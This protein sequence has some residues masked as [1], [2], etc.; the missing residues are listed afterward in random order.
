MRRVLRH[1]LGQ[2]VDL[3]IGHLQHAADVAQHAARLQGAEGD[4]LRHL[5]A[6]VA[7]LHV[8]DHLVA[9]VLAE[10]DVEVGHRHALGIEEALEQQAEADGIEIGDGE[11][12]GDQRARAR[13][14][15]GPDRNALRLR[16]FDEVGNDQE[17]A[18]IFHAL[19]DAEL[20]FQPLAVL[21]LGVALGEPLRGEPAGE[22]LLGL[23]AQFGGL[24]DLAVRRR[25]RSAAGSACASSAGRRSARRSRPWRPSPPA[26]RQ[27]IQAFPARLEAML[28][29]EL[30]PVALRE[31]AA[32]GDAD[33]RV[34][35]FVVLRGGEIGLVGGDQRQALGV[36][37][38][39]QRRLGG[40]L[41]GTAVALQFDIE[42]VAEQ[43][44][45]RLQ[46]R[47]GEMALPGG[48]RAVERAA[49]PAGERDHA[50]GFALEPVELQARRLVRRRVEEG[51]RIEPHQAA[52]AGLAGGQ[53]HHAGAL[54]M[55]VADCAGR[56]R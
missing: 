40:A 48:E 38:L 15:A 13:A 21:V 22:A 39:D 44:E 1:Q 10:V 52:V 54:G 34:V 5:I 30:A 50:F 33:Q 47:A 42:A 27:T 2:L 28:D 31:Q 56:G 53:Q 11:R 14:A 7:L 9:A 24:V 20:E 35:R 55:G 26:N 41:A 12:I 8:A 25:P 23:P 17:V 36:G 51:A 37:E 18:G 32:L 46:A 4:D 45:Q 16:P 6:A 49:G 43:L 3:A 29:R 19:D